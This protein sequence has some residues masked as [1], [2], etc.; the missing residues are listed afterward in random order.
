VRSTKQSAILPRFKG[1]A[2]KDYKMQLLKGHVSPET[3]YVVNDYPY[4]FRL[5]CKI[6][7]WLEF[8]AN[9]GFRFVSQT[10]NPKR[11]GEVWNKPKAS[12]YYRFGGAMFLDDEGHV[13]WAGLSEYSGGA[14]ASAFKEKYGEAVPE[15]G[16]PTMNQWVAAK[17]AYDGN[18]KSGDPLSVGL[19]EA[20]KAFLDEAL[21]EY[22]EAKSDE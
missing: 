7:Y 21:K 16:K 12:T 2:R 14:E 8:K 11:P 3:A 6:R 13:Q 5:R 10:T 17:V 1:Q 9:K 18:R 15:A 22:P 4:G 20:H 19:V